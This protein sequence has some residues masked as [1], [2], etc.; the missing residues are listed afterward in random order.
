MIEVK[1]KRCG[2]KWILRKRYYPN[3]I[4]CPVCGRRAGT[5]KTLMERFEVYHNNQRIKDAT[6]LKRLISLQKKE[7]IGIAIAEAIEKRNHDELIK[8]ILKVAPNLVSSTLIV[9]YLTRIYMALKD[10][11]RKLDE[12]IRGKKNS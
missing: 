5:Y 6:T 4:T 3:G 2:K 11:E 9:S 1:C 12:L 7:E 8:R 10:I